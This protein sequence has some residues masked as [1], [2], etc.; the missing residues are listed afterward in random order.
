VRIVRV[1]VRDP[2]GEL[3]QVRLSDD[4]TPVSPDR[5]DNRGV[6]GRRLRGQ[7]LASGCRY[8]SFYVDEVLDRHDRSIALLI[9]QREESVQVAP[10][11][12]AFPR[13]VCPHRETR[14]HAST[15]TRWDAAGGAPSGSIDEDIQRQHCADEDV[16]NIHGL[17]DGK[18]DGRTAD[19]IRLRGVEA[20]CQ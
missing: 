18:V 10:L 17:A 6:V 5:T 20:S 16:R 2:E 15:R 12:N 8:R 4:L 1:V 7:D 9:C 13:L 19:H 11:L 3:V 14:T